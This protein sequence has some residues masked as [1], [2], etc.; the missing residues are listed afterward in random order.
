[1]RALDPLMIA[2]L[3]TGVIVPALLAELTFRSSIQHAWTG[4]G[5]LTWNGHTYLGVGSLAGMGTISE[6]ME[7]RADGTSVSL[8]GIDPTLYAA[9][10]DD[11][12]LGASATIWFALLSGGV[13]IGTPYTLFK[14]QVDKPSVSTGADS[15][16]ISLAL[17]NRLTNLQH[18]TNRRYTAA[19]QHILYPT[20]T[21][22]NWVELLNDLALRWGS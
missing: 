14:G 15:I 18:A 11:I 3:Q 17:E 21:A 1:M 9:S 2:A 5:P 7:V 20:D 4:Y 19:D 13:F 22:F 6:G 10:M 8:S 12:Q 16:T